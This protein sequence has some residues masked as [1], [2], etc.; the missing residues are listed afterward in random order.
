[1]YICKMSESL[2][3]GTVMYIC[4]VLESQEKIKLILRGQDCLDIHILRVLIWAQAYWIGIY[5]FNFYLINK[6][7]ELLLDISAYLLCSDFARVKSSTILLKL[8]ASL[9]SYR[10]NWSHDAIFF[11]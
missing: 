7:R 4:K 8:L 2:Q 10:D 1:M 9:I 6:G 11:L 3:C 5:F